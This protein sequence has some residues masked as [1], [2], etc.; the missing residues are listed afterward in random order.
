MFPAELPDKTFIASLILSTRFPP[1]AVWSGVAGAFAVHAAIAVA[2]GGLLHLLP[3][4]DVEIVVALLFAGGSAYLLLVPEEREEERGAEAVEAAP[5]TV[6][7]AVL[8]AFV[9]VF[10]AE[11]GDITQVVAANLAAKYHD[12]VSVFTG[13]VLALWTVAALAVAGGHNLLRFVP[14]R[15]VRRVTGVVLA[16][17]AVATVVQLVS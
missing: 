7:R 8:S 3:H 14:L 17:L 6:R 4:Q 2:A 13:S 10:L 15:A 5:T 11:W 9:V 1:L 12:P 16:G